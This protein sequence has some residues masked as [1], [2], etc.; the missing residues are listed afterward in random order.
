MVIADFLRTSEELE[1]L[2]VNELLYGARLSL[3]VDLTSKLTYMDWNHMCVKFE[4]TTAADN[5]SKEI[6]S[7]LTLGGEIVAE[8]GTIITSLILIHRK[9]IKYVLALMKL[10]RERLVKETDGVSLF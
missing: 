5:K 10:S 9:P 1:L 6:K 8:E 7:T 2:V 4:P 3:S